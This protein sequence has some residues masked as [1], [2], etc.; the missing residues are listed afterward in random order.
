MDK[1]IKFSSL[2]PV[3]SIVIC[4]H[5][6]F[7]LFCRCVRGLDTLGRFQ[8]FLLSRQGSTLKGKNLL[9]RE[10]IFTF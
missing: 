6:R 1:A 9:K 3:S 5:V 4:I 7:L 10:K 2:C 8:T